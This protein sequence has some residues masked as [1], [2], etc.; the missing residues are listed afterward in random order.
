MKLFPAASLGPGFLREVRGP[1]GT[2]PLVPTGGISATNIGGFIAA[3]AVAVG[4]GGWLT[5]PGDPDVIQA[6]AAEL[7]G[8]I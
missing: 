4:V 6:R 8:A 5:G 3:G 7:L 2:I 1:L